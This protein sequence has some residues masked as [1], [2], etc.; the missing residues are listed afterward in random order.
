MVDSKPALKFNSYPR[1]SITLKWSDFDIFFGNSAQFTRYE[2][3]WAQRNTI[4]RHFSSSGICKRDNPRRI[5]KNYPR[6][7]QRIKKKELF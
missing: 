7:W 2:W 6:K 3:A 4:K 5:Q 1:E